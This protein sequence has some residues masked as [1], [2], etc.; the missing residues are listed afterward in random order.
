MELK[1][2]GKE[3]V[4]LSAQHRGCRCP[5]MQRCRHRV[6]APSP[7][8]SPRSCTG[9]QMCG[10]SL[11]APGLPPL[12]GLAQ[13]N[14]ASGSPAA[15]V[16]RAQGA[17]SKQNESPEHSKACV[18]CC[19]VPVRPSSALYFSEARLPPHVGPVSGEPS[20]TFKPWPPGAFGD[21]RGCSL[22]ITPF[23][24]CVTFHQTWDPILHSYI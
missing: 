2:G 4:V 10:L 21:S 11:R 3:F 15:C 1:A 19:L 6:S 9:I 18:L 20:S 22:P 24:A 13:G 14:E 16:A 5:A 8:P 7:P 17:R 12:P 23:Q